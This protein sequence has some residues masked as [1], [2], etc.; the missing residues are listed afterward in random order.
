LLVRWEM[1][2][3]EELVL[4]VQLG[5]LEPAVNGET[6]YDTTELEIHTVMRGLVRLC[7]GAEGIM[8]VPKFKG[9]NSAVHML[10]EQFL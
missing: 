5:F 6:C 8:S 4:R 9:C 2:R 3:P 7:N 10:Q 1:W